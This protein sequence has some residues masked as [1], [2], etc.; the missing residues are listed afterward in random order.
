[1]RTG[2]RQ[3]YRLTRPVEVTIDRSDITIPAGTEVYYLGMDQHNQ[4]LEL[5][6][7]DVDRV[8]ALIEEHNVREGMDNG[9]IQVELSALLPL[10][11]SL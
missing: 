9:Y 8:P 2:Y 1:M 11:P 5:V 7:V 4:H 10:T 3:V 6:I